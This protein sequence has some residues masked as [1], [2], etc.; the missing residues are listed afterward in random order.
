VFFVVSVEGIEMKC[1]RIPKRQ[2][3]NAWKTLSRTPL[4]KIKALKLSDKDFNHV[5]EHR[6]CPENSL[7]E[8]EEWGKVLSTKGTD[9]CVFSGDETDNA[10]YIL[11][12]RQ[13]PYHSL[14]KII[15]HELWH[16]ARGDL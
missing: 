3:V 15:V 8:I 4:P 2:L 10:E 9:S 7:L 16:I 14:H 11:L 13:K 5:L 1:E 12:V 6:Q